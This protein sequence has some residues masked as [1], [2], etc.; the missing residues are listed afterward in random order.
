MVIL[1]CFIF[2]RIGSRCLLLSLS[3][4]LSFWGLALELQ[5]SSAFY[6]DRG[7]E[8]RSVIERIWPGQSRTFAHVKSA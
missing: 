1:K 2:F 7:G 5:V 8:K 6:E 4:L 3:G